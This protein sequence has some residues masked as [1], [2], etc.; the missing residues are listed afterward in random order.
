MIFL[1][2]QSEN[3]L[4]QNHLTAYSKCRLL[5]ATVAIRD[6]ALGEEA[7]VR[8]VNQ[9]KGGFR[10]WED[11]SLRSR[12]LAPGSGH[13]PFCLGRGWASHPGPAFFRTEGE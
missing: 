13:L 12:A 2:I 9:P 3:Y 6:C 5:G 11:V 7:G 4:H 8:T 1:K 10:G